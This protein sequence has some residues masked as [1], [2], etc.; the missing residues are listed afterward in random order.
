[1]KMS[2]LIVIMSAATIRHAVTEMAMMAAMPIFWDPC[3]SAGVMSTD[4][5]G[6][7]KKQKTESA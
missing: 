1:M 2:L 7:V 3:A 4:K 5:S 6:S